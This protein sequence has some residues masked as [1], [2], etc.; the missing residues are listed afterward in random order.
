MVEKKTWHRHHG[1]AGHRWRL[2]PIGPNARRSAWLGQ[3][4]FASKVEIAGDTFKVTREVDGLETINLKAPAGTT[5]DL[6]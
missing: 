5:G 3:G 2:K 1:Q 4:T 6:P